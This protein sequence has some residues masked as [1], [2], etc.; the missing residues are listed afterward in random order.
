MQGTALP[1]VSAHSEEPGEALTAKEKLE[2]VQRVVSS[3]PF[4]RSPAMRAF[5]LYITEHSLANR[6]ERIKE[7]SIGWEVLGR[8]REY[9]PAEDNIVRVRAHELRQR[10]EKYFA[11]DGAQEP[12]V[13]TIPKGMYK[14]EFLPRAKTAELPA[15][16][17]KPSE[18]IAPAA[19]V[20]APSRRRWPD[21]PASLPA[22]SSL[23]RTWATA[24]R[25]RW[26]WRASRI[27]PLSPR[28]VLPGPP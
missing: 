21:I 23:S 25:L 27:T 26:T 17:S 7:Q 16:E 15:I 13:I 1:S 9:D 19:P 6:Y 10:L 24:S 2:L 11:T 20:V 4:S 5:L 22:L 12:Y 8:R 28:C 14:P 3:S 18:T